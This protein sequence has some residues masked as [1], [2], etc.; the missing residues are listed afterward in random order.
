VGV[1]RLKEKVEVSA[2]VGV[3]C[4]RLCGCRVVGSYVDSVGRSYVFCLFM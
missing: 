2:G 4:F 3:E 1:E